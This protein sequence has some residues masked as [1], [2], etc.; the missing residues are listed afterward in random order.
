MSSSVAEAP[1]PLSSL[2]LFDPAVLQC[3]HATYRRLRQEAPVLRD[4][5]TG[6]VQ[7]SGYDLVCK[8]A[9]DHVN[10]S[11]RFGDAL[12]GRG[13]PSPEAVAVMA[14]GYPPMDTMLTAD[15]PE[16][17]RY[18]KLVSKA[19]TPAR[20]VHMEGAIETLCNTLVDGFIDAGEV[21]LVSAFS[22]ALPLRVIAGQLGV[23][24]EDLPTFKRWSSAFVAQLS[25]M[26][27]PE[28]ELA[29][30]RDVVEFQHYFASVLDQR[31]AEPRDDIISDL[32]TVTLT[33]EG[34]PRALTTAEALS[35]LQQLLVAGNETTAHTITEGM[36]LLIDHPDQMEAV[37]ADHSLIPGLVEET[38]RMLTPTQN[39][40]RI[41]TRD[42]EV[43]GVAIAAGTVL[44]LRYGSANR[45]EERFPDGESFDIRRPN[46][47]RHL[48]FGYGIHVCIGAPL[49]RKE[50]LVAFRVLLDRIKGWRFA[51]GKNDFMHPPSIL[52][53]GMPHLHLQFDRPHTA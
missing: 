30:A 14:T 10:F 26:A 24:L 27:G 7:V 13:G 29:A 5:A 40:W 52:L 49:A 32:A 44:L 43:G 37:R 8:V 33:E 34:D 20:V 25:Q 31:R 9:Y 18:R 15:P 11:N 35:I 12:R 4:P 53:R 46:V 51:P 16:Q 36:K 3:P 23:P 6:I 41:A 42:C 45:D 22:Q 47:K 39:M 1:A 28:A 17:T 19:F 50:L 38:L 2:S 48:A 21:E